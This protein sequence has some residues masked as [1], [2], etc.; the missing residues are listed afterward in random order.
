MTNEEELSKVLSSMKLD[1][2]IMKSEYR[3]PYHRFW[4]RLGPS[5]SIRKIENKSREIGLAIRSN[6][7][8]ITPWFNDGHL[9]DVELAGTVCLELLDGKHP[10]IDFDDLAESSGF[11]DFTTL[12][13]KYEI[14]WLIGTTEVTNPLVVDLFSF[15][16]VLIAGT[17]GSG[18]SKGLH[19][20]IRSIDMHAKE[21]MVKLVLFD[22]KHVEFS[23][24]DNL[25]STYYKEGVFTDPDEIMKVMRN[26]IGEM[27]RRLKVLK[28]SGCQNLKQYREKTGKG[29][30]IVLVIDELADLMR[31]TNKE[32]EK[33]LERLCAKAR[34]AGI[35]VVAA[36]QYPHT[37]VITGTIKANFDGRIAF[38]VSEA[39][40]SR[41]MLGAKNDQAVNLEGKGDAFIHAG[42]YN[43][44]RFRGVLVKDTIVNAK[45]DKKKEAPKGNVFSRLFGKVA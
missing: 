33:N 37:D 39:V 15:P 11:N 26:L 2:Q 41:V 14:P 42:C 29:A 1:A 31:T 6:E 10:V 3:A 12:K 20:L 34:S 23:Q 32:F 28:S 17:T 13:G 16:H 18:K 45:S 38:R 43:M 24:Y 25:K 5:C 27:E 7:P 8:M 21:N 4:L 35:H 9:E 19:T 22:P 36:T 40:H 30:Y 44:R